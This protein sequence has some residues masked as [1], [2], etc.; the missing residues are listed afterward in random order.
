MMDKVEGGDVQELMDA[1]ALDPKTAVR[2]LLDMAK[3][4]QE[5]HKHGIVYR[6]LKPA[7]MLYD[8]ST[9]K[10]TMTD[11]GCCGY[12]SKTK[13]G[14]WYGTP[15]YFSPETKNKQKVT[16]ASDI[17]SFGMVAHEMLTGK[18]FKSSIEYQIAT[19]D[20]RDAEVSRSSYKKSKMP[21]QAKGH[22]HELMNECFRFKPEDRI[23][24]GDLVEHL[25][26]ILGEMD[27]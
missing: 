14:Q 1:K 23:T 5:L 13:D 11:L 19:E 25:T 2:V 17:Y 12:A 27:K 26:Y 20:K 9:K 15:R 3:G 8:E 24:A 21:E 6:D 16:T 18:V 22:M 4:L 10:A 7:N